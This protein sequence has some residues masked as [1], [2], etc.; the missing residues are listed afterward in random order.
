MKRKKIWLVLGFFLLGA[1]LLW[2]VF[3][4]QNTFEKLKSR[5]GRIIEAVYGIGTVVSEKI[6]QVRLGVIG[7]L[8]QVYVREGDF[9]ESKTP[10]LRVNA[11][12]FR[13]PFGGVVTSVPF[14][15]GENVSPNMPLLTLTDLKR[16]Y[17][18]VS[19]EQ[20]GALRIKKGQVTSISFDSLRG[21]KFAGKVRSVFPNADQFL[22]TVDMDQLPEEILPGMTADV[23]IEISSKENALLIPLR[24]VSQGKILIESGGSRKKLDVKIGI[25]DGEWA[26]ILEPELSPSDQILAAR[27]AT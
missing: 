18:S 8:D 22:V 9:V 17:L 21:Q 16:R 26:E 4:K 1:G 27:K 23:A 25:V 11:Q 6:Y 24:A 20:Q 7:T 15:S 13:S 19:L 10:L 14:N 3:A 5:K 12:I 2:L